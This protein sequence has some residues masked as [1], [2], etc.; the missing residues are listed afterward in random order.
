MSSATSRLTSLGRSA[1]LGV[2]A[3]AVGA[4]TARLPEPPLPQESAAHPPPIAVDPIT[5]QRSVEIDV[6][7]YN[8][9]ALP[10]PIASDR[11][12]ALRLIGE[13]LAAMR[14]RGTEPDIVM[15]QE[16]FRRS[17]KY[18]IAA[19][20]Y[21]NWVRGPLTGDR[22][23]NFSDRAP[24]EFRN[25]RYFWKGERIG[26]IMDGGLY[27]LSNWPIR[28]KLAQPFYRHEC[29][30]FDCGSNKGMLLAQVDVPGMPGHLQIMTTHLNARNS[31]GVPQARSLKA[32]NLQ[33]DHLDEGIDSN[34]NGVD[35]YIFGGDFNVKEARERLDYITSPRSK[36]EK[37]VEIV[38]HYCTVVVD[39]CDIRASFDGDEPWLDTNDWQGWIPGR[40]VKV[41][42]VMVDALFDAPH[43]QA[44]EIKGRRT[45]S[46]HDGLLVRYRLSWDG[47]AG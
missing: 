14:A 17:I 39:D 31:T 29:A 12:K 20:G 41:R 18:L 1:W 28:A 7:I 32:H 37:P 23:P 47:P 46:D 42:A 38:H 40:D 27:V 8:V 3:V 36:T 6:L 5:G 30:G 16:G 22:M 21:P 9:A 25:E 4:C 11:T 33:I 13:E 19:S 26:K 45:L 24:E 2:L 34:W 10:W 43:P 35:P 15:I 44:P